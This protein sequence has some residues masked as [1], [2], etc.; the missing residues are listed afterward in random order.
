MQK[1]QGKEDG[2]TP[3]AL[4]LNSRGITTALVFSALLCVLLGLEFGTAL[5]LQ[6]R[7]KH[8]R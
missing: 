4:L 6:I 2:S 3:E 8:S 5:F 1:G 7:S